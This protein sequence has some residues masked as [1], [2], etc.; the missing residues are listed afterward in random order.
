MYSLSLQHLKLID[1]IV[2][3]GSIT[4]AAE[5]LF[6]T[7]PALSHQLRE[8][9]EG[10]GIPVFRRISKKLVLT[11]AGQR[12]LD[13]AERV[14]PEVS[15]LQNEL[16]ELKE[17]KAGTVRLSTECY[18]CY[19][20][21]PAVIHAF[22]KEYGEV[23]VEIVTE[24]TR[25]PLEYLSAGKLDVAIVSK[26]CEDRGAFTYQPLFDDEMV[27]VVAREH[28]LAGQSSVTP[29]DFQDADVI[30][31]DVDD[32][33]SSL[34]QQVLLPHGIQPRSIQKMQLTEAIIEMV[35]ANLGITMLANW[36]VKPFLPLRNIVA[37]PFA[38]PG[39]RRTWHTA[40]FAEPGP[41]VTAFTHF[42]KAQTNRWKGWQA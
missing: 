41:V 34:I 42:T 23:R 13:T 6:V 19:H 7:Q 3:E 2:R 28:P 30:M 27:M 17:G 32:R 14:L 12:M 9:E 18:T 29:A 20:W 5:K 16:V 37:I 33:T 38:S 1:T 40:T 25:R 4:Q 22:R 36:A 8:L 10:L 24:A 31:Y 15:R 11:E 39:R 26:F 35:S 21:L